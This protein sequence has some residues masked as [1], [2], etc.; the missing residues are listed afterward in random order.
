MIVVITGPTGVGKKKKKKKLSK[1]I[2]SE[3]INA[4]SIQE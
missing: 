4:D 1:R 2:Y 3:I